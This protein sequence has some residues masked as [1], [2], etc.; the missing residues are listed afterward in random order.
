MNWMRQKLFGKRRV[1]LLYEVT[2][3][4]AFGAIGFLGGRIGGGNGV[5]FTLIF[6]AT[7]WMFGLAIRANEN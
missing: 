4:L 5:M 6:F 1:S 3:S 2:L 7:A